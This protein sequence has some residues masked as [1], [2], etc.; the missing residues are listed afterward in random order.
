MDANSETRGRPIRADAE[1]NRELIVK[2]AQASISEIGPET[3]L[4]DI[5]KRAHVGIGT[6]Y[7]HFP[8][9]LDLLN[10]VCQDQKEELVRLAESLKAAESPGD[11]FF[12][13][14]WAAVEKLATFK[15]LKIVLESELKSESSSDP[16]QGQRMS[17]LV[18]P[19]YLRASAANCFAPSLNFSTVLRLSYAIVSAA[20]SASAP[21]AEART[22]F[23][24]VRK[25][26]CAPSVP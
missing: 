3:P 14:L 23:D 12:A 1:R 2:V 19:L 7:R 11:A 13:W 17:A 8:T 9:R 22:L 21:I 4:E 18:E 6:L 24:I 20:E 26:L 15:A 5:A 16:S 25:G 10:A